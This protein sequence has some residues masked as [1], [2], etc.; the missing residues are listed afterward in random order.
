M[1]LWLFAYN[2]VTPGAAKLLKERGVYWSTREDLDWL[3]RETG[4]RRL[5]DIP[6]S[7]P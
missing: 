2:G 3:I 4:L 5:P 7:R 6:E 1:S